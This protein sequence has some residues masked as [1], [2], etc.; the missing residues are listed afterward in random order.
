MSSPTPTLG[1]KTFLVQHPGELFSGCRARVR[2]LSQPL[3]NARCLPV[4]AFVLRFG[5]SLH[6]EGDNDI[7]HTHA[8]DSGGEKRL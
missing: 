1:A 5:S 2:K 7:Y 4:G 8:G 3:C 6:M